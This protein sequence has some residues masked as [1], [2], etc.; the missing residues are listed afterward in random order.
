MTSIL[1]LLIPESLVGLVVRLALAAGLLMATPIAAIFSS[2]ATSTTSDATPSSPREIVIAVFDDEEFNR[3]IL[4]RRLPVKLPGI[5]VTVLAY[6]SCTEGLADLEANPQ[7]TF[8]V[9]VMDHKLSL[10]E[11]PDAPWGITCIK[12][13]RAELAERGKIAFFIGYSASTDVQQEFLDL[14]ASF[15][16]KTTGAMDVLAGV[17]RSLLGLP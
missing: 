8:D 17:I 2:A 9:V 4:V 13:V 7:L 5:P 14:G 1:R 6:A 16:Q 11:T 12:L 15:V 3:S 10:V